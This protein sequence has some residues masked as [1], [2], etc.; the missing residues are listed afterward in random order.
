MNEFFNASVPT[1]QVEDVKQAMDS[2]A[3]YVLL[4][5]RTK[6]EYARG[7]IEGSINIPLDELQSQVKTVVEEKSSLVYTYCLSGSRSVLAVSEMQEMGYSNVFDVSHGLLAWRVKQF[8]V[9]V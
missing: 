6:E 7:H 2:G 1:V 9:V 4:D 8:P 5:V 3:S